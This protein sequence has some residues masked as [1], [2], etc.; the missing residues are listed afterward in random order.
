MAQLVR[1]TVIGLVYVL[2]LVRKEPYAED[3]NNL[4]KLASEF[5]TVLTLTL[6]LALKAAAGD[7]SI[8]NL[9]KSEEILACCLC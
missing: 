5:S 8:D 4:L 3:S 2:L 1:A 6:S 7:S 9:G